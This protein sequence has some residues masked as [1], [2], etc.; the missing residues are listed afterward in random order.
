MGA[1][2]YLDLM[3]ELC[4]LVGALL[5]KTK[6]WGGICRLRASG[7]TQRCRALGLG[8]SPWLDALFGRSLG[9]GEFGNL[10][11]LRDSA[12]EHMA[13]QQNEEYHK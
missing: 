1:V 3:L 7:G 6:T 9:F 5:Y 4:D 13:E 11:T 2:A 10:G 8:P 12:R